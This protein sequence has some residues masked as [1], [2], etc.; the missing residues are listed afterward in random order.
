MVTRVM[1]SGTHSGE[2]GGIAPT[3]KRV[4]YSGIAIDRIADGK[5][6]ESWHVAETL[7]LFQQ[8]GARL[9][10]EPRK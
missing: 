7:S 10:A 8:I 4:K 6:V 9:S 3:G 5:V 2:F 1:F